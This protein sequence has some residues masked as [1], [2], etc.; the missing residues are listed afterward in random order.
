MGCEVGMEVR[1]AGWDCDLGVP[2][3]AGVPESLVTAV[4]CR[5]LLNSVPEAGDAAADGEDG[6]VANPG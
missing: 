6:S 1:E 5:L 3:A 2:L 4:L